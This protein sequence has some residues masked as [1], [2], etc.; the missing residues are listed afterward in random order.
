MG[1][2][3]ALYLMNGFFSPLYTKKKKFKLL[4]QTAPI[5]FHVFFH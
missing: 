2:L 3:L 1:K 4:Q 5:S